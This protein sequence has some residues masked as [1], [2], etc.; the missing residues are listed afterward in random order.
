MRFHTHTVGSI[1]IKRKQVPRIR[2]S[3]QWLDR[4]GFQPGR[5]FTVYELS[6]CLILSL[7]RPDEKREETE[8]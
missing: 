7:P 4:N 6:G 3:G 2:L 1:R 5:K 8:V